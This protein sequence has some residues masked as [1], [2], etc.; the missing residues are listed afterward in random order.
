MAKKRR[1]KKVSKA[2][3]KKTGRRPGRPPGSGRAAAAS[4]S[5]SAAGAIGSIRQALAHLE[6][7]RAQLDRQ[8][9]ALRTALRELGQAA[10]ALAAAPRVAAAPVG[11]GGGRGRRPRAGSLKEFIQGV[12]TQAGGVMA[13]RD[14]T[15]G[16]LAAGYQ[17]KNQTLAKSVGIALTEMP[18]VI[19]VG[20]GQFRL[21]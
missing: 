20:R 9:D 15:D 16:V 6:N 18:G 3:A 8:I 21:K 2:V 13:V 17:S 11:G 10:P 12:L 1:K 5:G 7:D 14:I 4:A 19:K